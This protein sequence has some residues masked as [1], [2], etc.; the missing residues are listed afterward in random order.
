VD[1]FG[2]LDW[3]AVLDV[4]DDANP[5]ELIRRVRAVEAADPTCIRWTR[6]KR[7]DDATIAYAT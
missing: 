5:T 7:S 4:L 3:P 2:L 6:N 1:L